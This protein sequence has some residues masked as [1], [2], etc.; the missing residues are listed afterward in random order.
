VSGR[1]VASPTD[2]DGPPM[3]PVHVLGDDDGFLYTRWRRVSRRAG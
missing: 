2:N 3:Q 1:I